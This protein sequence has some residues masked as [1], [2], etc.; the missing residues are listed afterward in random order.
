MSQN[1]ITRA[2]NI[3]GGCE[4]LVVDVFHLD[5]ESYL[6]NWRE[7]K[8]K[9]LRGILFIDRIQTYITRLT[10]IIGLVVLIIVPFLILI[11]R[12]NKSDIIFLYTLSL[13]YV[14]LVSLGAGYDTRLFII[15]NYLQ[16][17]QIGLLIAWKR[18]QEER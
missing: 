13:I 18:L 4:H 17:L 5:R 3:T 15:F 11:K 1:S 16:F 2:P 8:L 14:V 12:N 6:K 10:D 7:N 9:N